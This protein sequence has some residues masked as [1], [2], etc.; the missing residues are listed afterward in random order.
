[1]DTFADMVTHPQDDGQF[2]LF[3]DDIQLRGRSGSDL[4]QLLDV[5]TKW[6]NDY[7]M[8]WGIKKCHA[9]SPQ[10]CNQVFLIAGEAVGKVQEAE[11]LGVTISNDGIT[12]TQLLE[13]VRKSRGRTSNLQNIG[14]NVSGF[15]TRILR[16]LYWTFI[17]PMYEYCFHITPVSHGTKEELLNLEK[18]YFHA[19]VPIRGVKRNWYRKLFRIE[20]AM[21]RRQ[22]LRDSMVSRLTHCDRLPTGA[23]EAALE[24]ADN[25]EPTPDSVES[26][27]EKAEKVRKI[28]LKPNG[29]KDLPPALL[30]RSYKYRTLATK[31]YLHKFPQKPH[32]VRENGGEEGEAA[33]ESLERLLRKESLSKNEETEVVSAVDLILEKVP[34]KMAPLVAEDSDS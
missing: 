30:L 5:A 10:G 17:R 6:A 18:Q 2:L 27:T 11:Y 13:R 8:T 34:N 19:V 20:E 31:W 14:M 26:W 33:L 24:E 21:E 9:L 16:S 3:A 32:L 15:H 1:M 23:L 25:V 4:Q 22:T 28:P 12:S 7:D 29:D